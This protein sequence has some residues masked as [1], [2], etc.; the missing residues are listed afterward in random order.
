VKEPGEALESQDDSPNDD[1]S[2]DEDMADT[3][4]LTEQSAEVESQPQVQ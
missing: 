4:A 3:G 2:G 1:D